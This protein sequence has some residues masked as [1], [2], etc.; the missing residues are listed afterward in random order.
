[1]GCAFDCLITVIK[2]VGQSFVVGAIYPKNVLFGNI[3]AVLRSGTVFKIKTHILGSGM[4]VGFV[5][6]N[7]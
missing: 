5:N 1:M 3:I 6:F 2:I 7:M 4:F